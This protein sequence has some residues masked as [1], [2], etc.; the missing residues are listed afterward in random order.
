MSLSSLLIACVHLMVGAQAPAFGAPAD[1]A[2]LGLPTAT[3]IAVD[4]EWQRIAEQ[5]DSYR[6]TRKAA[7]TLGIV[8]SGLLVGSAYLF[9][10]AFFEAILGGMDGGNQRGSDQLLQMAAIGA[11]TG[12]VVEGTAVGFT[13]A[14]I[15]KGVHL[16]Q[17]ERKTC[18]RISLVPAVGPR[19]GGALARLEF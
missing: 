16:R 10:F 9:E 2:A 1:G 12:V 18:Y 14:T 15:V 3:G 17:S 5:T 8:G 7:F 11:L 6:H 13:V 4:S 19:G